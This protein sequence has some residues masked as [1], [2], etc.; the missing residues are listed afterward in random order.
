MKVIIA[1]S[2]TIND[3]RLVCDVIYSASKAG[4]TT[5]EVVSGTAK[6]V[7]Q[8]AERWAEKFR[9]PVK[10]FPADWNKYGKSA[11]YRRNETMANYADA[12][13]CLW[14]GISRGTAHMIN[15]ARQKKLP[16][17]VF[18]LGKF[19]GK[20]NMMVYFSGEKNV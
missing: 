5:T 15:L 16:T 9:I 8:L 2:R 19:V 13:I 7:D 1:G 11:G 12:C 4:I 3:I 14:D 6:G 18:R 20:E 17:F 10:Q